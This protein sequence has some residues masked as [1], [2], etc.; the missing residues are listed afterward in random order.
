MPIMAREAQVVY[1]LRAGG[2]GPSN[3]RM[4]VARGHQRGLISVVIAPGGRTAY[5][6]GYGLGFHAAATHENA[7]AARDSVVLIALLPFL[8]FPARALSTA[9]R[10][11]PLVALLH[12]GRWRNKRLQCKLR[13]FIDLDQ[14]GSC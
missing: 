8:V 5:P 14:E 12:L 6:P 11:E 9:E 4:G 10:A 13:G 1:P 3:G 2:R 7:I